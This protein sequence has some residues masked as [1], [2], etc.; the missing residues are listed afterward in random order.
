MRK[1]L[2]GLCLLFAVSATAQIK[3]VTIEGE[4]KGLGNNEL[5]LLNVDQSVIEK[6]QTKD[7]KF[8]II[9]DMEIGDMRMYSLYAPSVGPLGP[10]MSNPILSF[11]GCGTKIKIQAL[12]KDK[13]L[14]IVS[15]KG[16]AC[17]EEYDKIYKGLR[18]NKAIEAASKPY[19]EAFR[20]YNRVAKTPEN[21]ARLNAAGKQ[22]DLSFE[23]KQEEIK[24]LVPKHPK[25]M[26]V[27]VMASLYTMHSDDVSEMEAFLAQFDPAIQHC[28][29][30]KQIQ[31][32]IARL[33]AIAIGAQAPDFEL[34]DLE[35][36][37]ISLKD[38]K[39]KYVLLDFWASWCGPCRKENPNVVKAYE[40]Y[41]AKGFTV[42][43]VSLDAKEADWRKAVKEDGM[44]WTQVINDKKS[45]VNALYE[46][47][48]IPA[49]FLIDPRGK[50]IATNLRGAE[51]EKALEKFIIK[52]I[53]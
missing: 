5:M 25:S 31:K 43:G 1:I 22:M 2:I 14:S 32:K 29:Y 36:K 24:A 49:N 33:N 48:A 45:R 8:Q 12:L 35:G 40:G 27:A 44:P 41:K 4:V 26:P 23:Q 16:S 19:N 30:L 3:K 39:G 6:T 52:D 47:K 10:S 38:F 18:A 7:G 42:L 37:L 9:A 21:K 17:Q 20:L 46:I 28:Y 13:N 51:L 53:L 34:K 15:I 50:I 11:F